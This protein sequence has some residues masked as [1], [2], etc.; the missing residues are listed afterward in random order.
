MIEKLLDIR[1]SMLDARFLILVVI[2]SP[3]TTLRA[4][5]ERSEGIN[6]AK[7]SQNNHSSLILNHLPEGLGLRI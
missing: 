6:S 5:P 7:Q 4:C 2:A 1:Y 3:S